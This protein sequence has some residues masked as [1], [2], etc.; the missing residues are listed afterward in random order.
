MLYVGEQFVEWYRKFIEKITG[1][2]D[3]HIGN[4]RLLAINYFFKFICEELNKSLS[5]DKKTGSIKTK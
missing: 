2:V 4:E 3:T 5:D 1:K